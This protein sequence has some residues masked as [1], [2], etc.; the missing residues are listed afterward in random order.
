MT[1]RTCLLTG[2]SGAIGREI[3]ISLAQDGGF[4]PIFCQFRRYCPDLKSLG[5]CPEIELL[6][7]D[8][9]AGDFSILPSEVDVLVNCAGVSSGKETISNVPQAEVEEVLKLNAVVPLLLCQRFIPSMVEKRFGRVININSIWGL[10]GSECNVVYNMS[11]HALRALTKSIAKE[12]GRFGVTANDVCPGPIRSKMMT[13]IASEIA[14]RTG[15]T[16]QGVLA[17]IADS[18][19]SRRLA[20]PQEVAAV[21]NFLASDESSGVNGCAICVDGGTI[22]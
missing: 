10:R 17:R 20:E 9:L 4:D 15:G 21:V 16:A 7:V 11:K 19:N 1:K 14:E 5:T 8:L 18:Q 12:C 22:S 3:A 6:Q 2:V 13:R